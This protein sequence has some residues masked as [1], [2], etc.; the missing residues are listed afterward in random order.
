MRFPLLVAILLSTLLP[1]AG[2][3]ATFTVDRADDVPA[4]SGCDDAT[5]D[6]C[7]LRGAIAKSNALGTANVVV[8]PAG[9]YVLNEAVSCTYKRRPEN[10]TATS[11]Q[12]PLCLS[13]DLTIVG[14]GANETIIDANDAVRAVFVSSAATV[15]IR[16]LTIQN[17]L[18][19]RSFGLNP[20]GGNINNHGTLTL[21]DV[22]VRG[23]SLD[24]VA[25]G[26]GGAGIFNAEF[27]TLTLVRTLVTQNF[28]LAHAG[29]GGLFNNLDGTVTISDSTFHDNKIGVHGGAIYNNGGVMVISN[30]T[31]S[32]NEA[33]TGNGGGIM[34]IGASIDFTEFL[35][36]LT[37]TNSTISGNTSGSSG[38]GINDHARSVVRLNN[39]TITGNTAASR[40]GTGGGI[41]TFTGNGVFLKNTVVA[42]NTDV[43]G[44]SEDCWALNQ[45]TSIALTSEGHNLIGHS[46]NCVLLG[47]ATGNVVDVSADLGALTE[48]GGPT[49]TH[50]PAETSPVV[51][52]GNPLPPGAGG[53][54][55]AA[56]DQRGFV[57]PA[58]AAC[59]IGAVERG[60][61]F[62][63]TQIRPS[64]GG[65]GGTVSAAVA[66]NGFA[67]G[68]TV[69]LV[70]FGQPDIVGD[71]VQVDVG[72]SAIATVFDLTGAAVGAWDVV[73]TN[74]DTTSETLF[75]GFTVEAGGAPD[76]WVDVT[77]LLL[78]PSRTS[79]FT[80]FYG[81]RGNVDALA[82]PLVVSTSSA[83][84][85]G[86][87]FAVTPPPALPESIIVDW[88]RVPLH[89]DDEGG[90]FTTVPLLL[91]VVPAGSVGSLQVTITLPPAAEPSRLFVDVDF[92]YVDASG[93]SPIGFRMVQGARDFAL[94]G[95]DTTIPPEFI[96][97]MD[98]YVEDQLARVV[99]DGR[100]AHVESLGTAPQVY[101]VA[102]L[103]TDTA[104]FG[105][106]QA[107]AA[108]EQSAALPDWSR[109]LAAIGRGFDPTLASAEQQSCPYV[110]CKSGKLTPGCPCQVG[111]EPIL[112][113]EIPPPPG[114][115]PK[116]IKQKL[117]S[118]SGTVNLVLE[119]PT[120]RIT[121]NH[122]EAVGGVVVNYSD[123]TSACHPRRCD[124]LHPG[125]CVDFPLEPKNS[126]DPND[127]TGPPGKGE[128]RFLVNETSL[129][130]TV[131][132]ENLETAT[133]P[134]Q[135]VTITDQLDTDALDLATFTLGPISF[136][137]VVL[138]PTPGV[139]Q[140]SGGIDL[141]PAQ[142]LIVT[143]QAG[144]DEATGIVT[145]LFTSIDPTTGQ[146]TDEPDAGFLPPNVNPPEGN[147]SVAFAVARKP[148]LASGTTICNDASIVFDV[149]APIVTPEWCN[150]I[151]DVPPTSSASA[152]PLL[153]GFDFYVYWSG[154]DAG[155]G[156]A[157]YSI[158]YSFNGG[159]YVPWVIDA[160]G[161]SGFFTP[162]EGIYAFYSVA[163]D[164]A[165]NVEAPPLV[166]D[167]TI[168]TA[169][170]EICGNCF[171]DDLD[172][173]IDALDADCPADALTIKKASLQRGK[174][175]AGDEKIA[176]RGSLPLVA[177]NPPADGVT[178]A[179]VAPG[180]P[181][182]LLACVDVPPGSSG[183]K[184]NKKGTI[185]T[186]KDDK[187]GSLGDPSSKDKLT[188]KVDA[189]KQKVD[190]VAGS[191]LADV[192]LPAAGDVSVQVTSGAATWARTQAWR[193]TSKGK[194]AVTP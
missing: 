161:T 59:D 192:T 75:D 136:A 90:G 122:C 135:V 172:G 52:G 143:V 43:A 152:G 3:A 96:A 193:L 24:P 60:G 124:S 169:G 189:K 166:P 194:T 13:S 103:L 84:G 25:T 139:R 8:V 105:A 100:R 158:Y 78:R 104:L 146:L 163:R 21:T 177:V 30:S 64:A 47:D 74:P 58:G 23:A 164:H 171:D 126:A 129:A 89:F 88:S 62:A 95:F 26:A 108:E 68:A 182:V 128:A 102:Q 188:I 16:D 134:A 190:V 87:M 113:P 70:R 131:N 123:G 149:N 18:G 82:V 97:S 39:V 54:S 31:I 144:L 145:W 181:D 185:W 178:L 77:G 93:S 179:F 111:P 184:V 159:P 17:G 73:V 119:P 167:D 45:P 66:G 9:T 61:A 40:G 10:F 153:P 106:A 138:T 20:N 154:S 80:I 156:V 98:A 56:T 92:P 48:N 141:R 28:A 37:I 99:A 142:N 183:W 165:G 6:D 44:P 109:V 83:Y 155:A 180:M 46:T 19:D 79:R 101:S 2:S 191:T 150:T 121:P 187:T 69:K 65:N 42:G 176:L 118:L 94:E 186:F 168:N 41:A 114:C 35:A 34:N 162:V 127:K 11:S 115:D 71:P 174:V 38:G 151:D 120:C 137:D 51:D 4:A 12:I 29:G 33:I 170:P 63:V 110:S 160:A 132:F 85:F 32:G 7:S 15:E 5:A 125:A 112:P 72:G 175:I 67:A 140:W 116:M 36:E 14:A 117:G 76:V 107:V 148:G 1:G 49:R 147:G 55:C 53:K 130:Y 50:A 81:N 86:R 22:I 173:K 133:A 91:P 157:D 57:R 27:A